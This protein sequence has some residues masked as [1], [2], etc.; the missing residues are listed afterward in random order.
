MAREN[1]VRRD[2]RQASGTIVK[3]TTVTLIS[4]KLSNNEH[5]AVTHFSNYV[6][7][8]LAWGNL[9]WRV[10]KNRIPQVPIDNQ[11]D[12]RGDQITPQQILEEIIFNPCDLLEITVQNTDAVNDWVAGAIIKGD[13]FRVE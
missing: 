7:A 5:F 12:Q 11:K 1:I 4:I 2:E 10:L 9:T 13:Y 3:A 8:S 6:G